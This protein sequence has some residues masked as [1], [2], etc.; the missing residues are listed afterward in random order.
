[1]LDWLSKDEGQ[2]GMGPEYSQELMQAGDLAHRL[3]RLH[4]FTDHF[5]NYI[6]A[7][8][9]R[10]GLSITIDRIRLTDA[11][12]AWGEDF[13]RQR[14]AAA[15]DRQDYMVFTAGTLLTHLIKV[16]PVAV[17]ALAAEGASVAPPDDMRDIIAFWPEGFL[18]TSYCI[19]VLQVVLEQ[20]TRQALP[21]S[22]IARDL[23]SW[24]SFRENVREDR[25]S[26]IGFF[27]LFVGAEPN[28]LSPS[29][30]ADRPAMRKLRLGFPATAVQ[31]P[32]ET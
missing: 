10:L 6:D 25:W 31:A 7:L 20:E 11:F 1:M 28:W 21:M 16:E 32:T 9:A 5:R 17:Q 22:E 3:R 26:A 13:T 30:A 12:L 15:I 18:Y 14:N 23:R 24:W 19:S 29:T 27:D 8:A 4:F 2:G